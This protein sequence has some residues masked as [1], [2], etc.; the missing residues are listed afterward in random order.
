MRK[1]NR[2]LGRYCGEVMVKRGVAVCLVLVALAFALWMSLGKEPEVQVFA[3]LPPLTGPVIL[4]VTGEFDRAAGGAMEFDLA[5]LQALDGTT[6][7]TSSIWT[8]GVHEYTGVSLQLLAAYLGI[9]EGSLLKCAAIND[10]VIDVPISDAVA[11][12][13]IIAYAMDGAPMS[14]RDK[15]PLWLLYPFDSDPDYQSEVIYTRSIWQLDRIEVIAGA[16]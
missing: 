15:G 6:F 2:L 10:Y 11:E 1:E 5:M 16:G 4:T 9:A 8:D 12:G 7:S 3:E 14:V 13:P